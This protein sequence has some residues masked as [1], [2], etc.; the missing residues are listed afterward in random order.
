MIEEN[1]KKELMNGA[2]GICREN[3]PLSEHTSFKIGGPAEL[4]IEPT[5]EKELVR[6]IRYMNCEEI[7]YY[8]F[9]RGSNVLV[10]DGGMDGVCIILGPKYS[11]C[12]IEGNKLSAEAGASINSVSLLSFKAGLTGM[13]ELSGIPGSVGGGAIMNAG[14]YGR[15]MKDVIESVRV[16]DKDGQISEIGIED[17]DMAYRSSRMMKEGLII[18]RVNFSLEPGDPEEIMVKYEDYSERRASKQPLDKPSAGSTFKRPVG[19]Y[20]SKLIDDT[21]LRGLSCG[22]AQVSEKHCGFLINNGGAKASEVLEL[23][24]M[25]REKVKDKFG[26][27]LEPEVRIIGKD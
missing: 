5:S 4:L 15:E 22:K 12:W 25:V 14:A 13:E 24:D 16:I 2:Y 3:V 8:V 20:A 1:R 11:D 18:S 10:K 7:P 21:G 27:E 9:G 17:M 6:L 19:G 26:I 23:I